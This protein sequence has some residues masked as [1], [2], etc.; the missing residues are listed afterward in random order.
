MRHATL[1]ARAVF[2]WRS[3][4][5]L[6]SLARVAG[7]PGLPGVASLACLSLLVSGCP[8]VGINQGEIK[9]ASIPAELQADYA[10]FADRCSKCHSVARAFNQGERDDLFWARYV[11]RMR[12]QPAS[13]IAPS[14]EEPILRFLRYYSAE[15]RKERVK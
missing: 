10:L 7:L 5:S 12:R 4:A 2:T 9:S 11:T 1:T 14:E 15:L 3:L 13:G 6:A 8:P